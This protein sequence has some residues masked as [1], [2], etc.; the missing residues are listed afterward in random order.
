MTTSRE[1]VAEAWQLTLAHRNTLFVYGFVPALFSILI[2][3]VYIYYQVEAFRH[4]ALVSAEAENLLLD[5]GRLLLQFATQ[6]PAV[7]AL[8]ALVVVIILVGWLFAP[9]LARGA[10]AH[11]IA[12]AWRGERLGGGMRAA[13]DRFFTLFEVSLAK[14]ALAP[15]TFLS[16]FFFIARNIPGTLRILAPFLAFLLVVGMVGLFFTS[17]TTQAIMLQRRPFATAIS[18]SFRTVAEHFWQTIRLLILFL[19]VELRVI[20]NV[21]I[22]LL[23]PV[24]LVALTGVFAGMFA[25]GIGIAIS[26]LCFAVLLVLAAYLTGFLFV[27]SEAMWTV[28]FLHFHYEHNA[29]VSDLAEAVAPDPVAPAPAPPSSAEQPQPTVFGPPA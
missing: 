24:A 29:P 16:E 4:S 26:V 21:L 11:L 25:E 18:E 20:V 8:S 17:F 19:L 12:Q 7:L 3:G 22:V 14:G 15:L 13:L 27:F 1:I 5:M 10:I 28:A 9:M 23:L 6:S 2:T